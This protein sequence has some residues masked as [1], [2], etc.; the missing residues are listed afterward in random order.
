M[1]IYAG[2]AYSLIVAGSQPIQAV[3][4]SQACAGDR[5]DDGCRVSLLRLL[6]NKLI[7]V[8]HAGYSYT[9]MSLS[10]MQ[11]D[12]RLNRKWNCTTANLYYGD[13][14]NLC[15]NVKLIVLSNYPF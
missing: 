4:V 6:I 7:K 9:I 15:C 1:T 8:V 10:G 13:K 2:I 12:N 11:T 5:C 14:H 3:T